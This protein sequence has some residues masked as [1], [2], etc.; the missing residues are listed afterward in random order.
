MGSD[1]IFDKLSSKEAIQCAWNS[2][3]YERMNTVHKQCGIA[4]DTIMK[5]ALFRKS[6]DNVTTVIIAFENFKRKVESDIKLHENEIESKENQSKN[7]N[8][9]RAMSTSEITS[10]FVSNST[11]V[12]NRKHFAFPAGPEDI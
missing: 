6:L 3:K 7:S 2:L 9:Q 11:R 1:G 4:A 10:K 12:P 5:N 8:L